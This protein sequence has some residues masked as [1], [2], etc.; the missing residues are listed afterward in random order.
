[1]NE[2]TDDLLAL[3]NRIQRAHPRVEPTSEFRMA[4]YQRL[5]REAH[6]P[7]RVHNG[8]FLRTAAGIVA[9]SVAG[10]TVALLRRNSAPARG[11]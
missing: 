10:A 11:E 2:L 3:G 6:N 9:L 1:M 8:G 5:M 7:R 4:L